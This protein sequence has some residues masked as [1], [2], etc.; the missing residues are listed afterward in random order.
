MPSQILTY[1][2]RVCGSNMRDQVHVYSSSCP[3]KDC[4]NPIVV[5]TITSQE[6]TVT[7]LVH[8]VSASR[9][10]SP[11]VP[12][13]IKQDFME[14]SDVLPISEKASAARSRR[15]LQN[16]LND[17]KIKGKDLCAQ[18]EEALKILPTA[19]S[20][21]LDAIRQIGNFA[22]H[23]IKYKATG[24]IADVEPEEASWNLGSCLKLVYK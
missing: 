2:M 15:C 5:A 4:Q 9:F 18:I 17:R 20:E 23:P 6:T 22:A 14:A 13:E 10:V 19:I 21:N 3:N 7:R 1:E 12:K 11:D 8:P 16:L 24:E